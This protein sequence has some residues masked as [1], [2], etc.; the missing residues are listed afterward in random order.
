MSDKY[1]LHYFDAKY[2]GEFLR[3][4]MAQAGIKFED[5]RYTRE[6]WAKIKQSKIKSS[7]FRIN[8]WLIMMNNNF[9]SRAQQAAAIPGL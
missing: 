7:I 4:I 8:F 1:E 2:R 9:C 6:E 5:K 3:L